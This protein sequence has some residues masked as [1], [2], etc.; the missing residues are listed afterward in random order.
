LSEKD[1]ED[2]SVVPAH[3]TDFVVSV[4][5]PLADVASQ[6]LGMGEYGCLLHDPGNSD[7]LEVIGAVEEQQIPGRQLTDSTMAE[8]RLS[9]GISAGPRVGYQE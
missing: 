9:N 8:I 5:G 1:R 7:C 6:F 2:F 4:Y 3:C